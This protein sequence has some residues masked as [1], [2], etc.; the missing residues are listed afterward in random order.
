[1]HE[2]VY[3][4]ASRSLETQT[5]SYAL[6]HITSEPNGHHGL[7]NQV[8]VTGFGGGCQGPQYPY[9]GWVVGS[10]DNTQQ[11]KTLDGFWTSVTTQTP[12]WGVRPENFTAPTIKHSSLIVG[13]T[14]IFGLIV[15][16]MCQLHK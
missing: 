15:R 1:M 3:K 6:P 10:E 9:R 14:I 2:T 16:P 5:R 7:F 13:N 11:P 8:L 12:D 4:A